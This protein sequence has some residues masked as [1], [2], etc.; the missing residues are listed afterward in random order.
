M[1]TNDPDILKSEI[2]IL[3]AKEEELMLELEEVRAS[4]SNY[5]NVLEIMENQKQVIKLVGNDR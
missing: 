2:V 1:K 5:I 3:K 4:I